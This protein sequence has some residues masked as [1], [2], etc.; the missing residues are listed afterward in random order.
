MIYAG[1]TLKKKQ[2][3]AVHAGLCGGSYNQIYTR[4]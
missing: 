4:K 1:Y 3:R 2:R